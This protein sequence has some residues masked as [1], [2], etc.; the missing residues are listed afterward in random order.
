MNCRAVRPSATQRRCRTLERNVRPAA[1]MIELPPIL[2]SRHTPV[3]PAATLAWLGV[4]LLGGGSVSAVIVA[5]V[6]LFPR[7]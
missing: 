1:P 7:I 2:P 6:K 4:V 3:D 5:L